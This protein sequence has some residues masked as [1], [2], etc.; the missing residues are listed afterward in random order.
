MKLTCIKKFDDGNVIESSVFFNVII[1][2]N[3]GTINEAVSSGIKKG[4]YYVALHYDEN[5]N[6]DSVSTIKPSVNVSF[7]L[8]M[9]KYFEEFIQAYNS[10][11][12]KK[13][14][15]ESSGDCGG[16]RLSFTYYVE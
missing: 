16:G 10:N 6:L 3:D 5:C 7:N 8:E 2:I 9:S 11:D 15:I 13:Y 4:T 14:F 1:K 12:L